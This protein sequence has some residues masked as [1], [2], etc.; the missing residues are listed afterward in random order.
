MR[1]RSRP[2]VLSLMIR[3]DEIQAGLDQARCVGAEGLERWQ[4]PTGVLLPEISSR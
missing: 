1:R 3:L 2:V 4:R